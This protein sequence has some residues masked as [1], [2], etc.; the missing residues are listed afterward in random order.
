MTV[1]LVSVPGPDVLRKLA[2]VIYLANLPVTTRAKMEELTD[3][4]RD[5]EL[6]AWARAEQQGGE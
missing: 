3:I 2:R 5:R 6:V 1:K 4:T